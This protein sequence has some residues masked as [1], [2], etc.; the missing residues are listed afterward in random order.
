VP[1]ARIDV[2]VVA[3]AS[4]TGWRAA[5]QELVASLRRAGAEVAVAATGP[6]PRVRTFALTDL[7]EARAARRAAQA[8]IAAHDPRAVIYCS[9]TAALLWPR[10]GAI[11]LDSLAAEN[12][13]GRHGIWQ[14]TVERRRVDQAPL[15]LAMS[16]NALGG[17]VPHASVEVVP[18][19]VAASG[20]PSPGRAVD[21]LTYAGDPEKKRLDRVL[22]AWA[23]ARR[24]EERLVVAGLDGLVPRPGV[25]TVGRLSPADYRSLLRKARVF[26]AAPRREDYGIAPLEALADGCQL[27]TT[28]APGPYP[29]R[30]IARRV[31]PR[32][33][34]HD[35]ARA[36]RTALDDPLPDYAQRAAELLEPFSHAA[37]DQTVAVRVLPRLLS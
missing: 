26:V 21:A 30:E 7:V 2:L 12:R 23:G 22:E 27:V 13:P 9:I 11:W 19:P 36:I 3:V 31:D 18:V 4:T 37:V 6:L 14:R 1:G 10:P 29:A 34:S 15:V 24:G 20:P 28:P 33:V 8:G 35:L 32:L 16:P 17:L 5:T 25:E